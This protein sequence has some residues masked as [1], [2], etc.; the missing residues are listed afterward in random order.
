MHNNVGKMQIRKNFEH[1]RLKLKHPLLLQ[2]V[3]QFYFIVNSKYSVY[4]LLKPLLDFILK[5][6]QIRLMLV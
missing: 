3:L 4:N 1:N 5:I 2:Y 6:S